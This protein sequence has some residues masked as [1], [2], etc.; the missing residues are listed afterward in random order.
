MT[1]DLPTSESETSSFLAAFED[2]SLPKARWT[3]AAH[4]FTGACYVHSFGESAA[5]ARMRERVSAYNVAVGG[6]NTATSGYHETI[7]LFWIK[8]LAKAMEEATQLS[9][10][11]S[12]RSQFAHACVERFVGQKSIYADYYD[13]DLVASAEAR[14]IWMA[15]NRRPI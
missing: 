2:G 9:G 4:I 1:N 13:F 8:I 3:H 15:P 6:Q 12:A 11:R 5:I 14:Q 10:D 7:T